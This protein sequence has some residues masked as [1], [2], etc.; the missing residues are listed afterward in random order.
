MRRDTSAARATGFQPSG[1]RSSRLASV[2]TD[3]GTSRAPYLIALGVGG[4]VYVHLIGQLYVSEIVLAVLLPACFLRWKRKQSA[5][6]GSSARICVL[7]GLWLVGLLLSYLA[8]PGDS[9]NLLQ[10]SAAAVFTAID[11]VVMLRVIK[12]PREVRPLLFGIGVGQLAS[13]FFQ[14]SIWVADNAWKFGGG[15]GLTLIG[16]SLSRRNIKA[17]AVLLVMAL[18]SVASDS[19]SLALVSIITLLLS[20][21]GARMRAGSKI[22]V[23][24]AWA[25]LGTVGAGVVI[26]SLYGYVVH[27]GALGEGVVAKYEAQ[28]GNSAALALLGGRD[29]IFFSLRAAFERPVLGW[30]PNPAL[31][32]N[33]FSAGLHQLFSLGIPPAAYK[34][35]LPDQAMPVHSYLMGGWIYGGLLGLISWLATLAI[36]VRGTLR[37]AMDVAGSARIATIFLGVLTSWNILY[38]PFGGTERFQLAA[39]LVVL[40]ISAHRQVGGVEPRSLRATAAWRR[41]SLSQAPFTLRPSSGVLDRQVG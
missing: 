23:L 39:L 13:V 26:H 34:A 30:G 27:T 6:A 10:Y 18:A 22:W 40:T 33:I 25:V 21:L 28:G 36:V 7:M 5:L 20:V 15:V 14:P 31:P 19:R 1:A 12:S 32:N 2:V 41:A 17:Y 4:G 37:T 35:T 3:R 24:G 11:C 16:L 29:E 8:N 38:S 9:T